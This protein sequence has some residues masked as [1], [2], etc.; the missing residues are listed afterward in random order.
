MLAT[1]GAK[2]IADLFAVVPEKFRYPKLNLPEP[3]SEMEALAELKGIAEANESLDEYVSFLG[4]GAYHHYIPAGVDSILRRGEYYTAYTPY[5]PEISQGTLQTIFEYQSLIVALTGMQVSN[6]S[7][8]DG[9]TA[10]AEAVNMS[11]VIHR[12]ARNKVIL[13]PGLHPHYRSTVQTYERGSE[14][15]FIGEDLD[16]SAGSDRLIDLMAIGNR[17][18]AVLQ[19]G[20]VT[21]RGIASHGAILESERTSRLRTSRVYLCTSRYASGALQLGHLPGFW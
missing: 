18:R 7:H 17:S 20:G 11:R 12:G 3:L 6:A 13:S 2:S 5:Q 4:A 1:I 16:L 9:A 21:G 10:L 8:Y 14:M 19:E 15:Q